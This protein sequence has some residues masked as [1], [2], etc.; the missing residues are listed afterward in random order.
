MSKELTDE[1]REEILK[2]F[3]AEKEQLQN[4]LRKAMEE[5]DTIDSLRAKLAET[6]AK[7]T[8]LRGTIRKALKPCLDPPFRREHKEWADIYSTALIGIETVLHRPPS[9]GA[10]AVQGLVEAGIA[11]SDFLQ[12]TGHHS[13]HFDE[14]MEA[15]AASKKAGFF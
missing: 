13:Q 9:G 4:D 3:S 14:F 12:T 15:L 8:V 1:G 2:Q 11:L 5:Q 6:T 7:E 10:A